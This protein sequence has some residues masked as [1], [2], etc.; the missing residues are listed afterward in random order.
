MKVL[1]SYG[2]SILLLCCMVIGS[3]V[4]WFVGE[5]AKVVQPVADLFLNLLFTVV[6][7]LIFFSLASSIANMENLRK[8]GK[9]L[10]IMAGIFILTQV[11]ASFYMAGICI[12]FDPAKGVVVDMTEKVSDLSGSS[13]FLAMF[14]V[15]DFSL[16]WSRSNLM[17]LIVAAIFTGVAI[18]ACGEKGKP[19]MKFMDSLTHILIKIVSYIMYIAPIG[20]GCFFAVLVGEYGSQ[21]IGPLSRTI[22]IY[23]VAAVIYFFLSS[24]AYAWIAGGLAAFKSFWKHIIPPTLTSLGTCSSAATIPSNLLAAENMNIPDDVKDLTITMGCNLHKDG[25]CLITIL[26]I[27]FMCTMFNMNFLDPKILFTAILIS[28]VASSVMGAIPGGGYVGEIFII[29]AFGFPEVSIPIMVLIGTI[30]DAPATTINATGDTGAAMVIARIMNGKN[31]M[32]KAEK[33]AAIEENV[34]LV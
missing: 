2:F 32:K 23:M 28:V 16:L 6:V 11:I 20:L 34:T 29:S 26:K 24:S 3:I 12:L 9:M 25:A 30:T 5:S 27:A 33:P 19:V 31:W 10:G 4:G 13:N 18:V 15:K 21:L 8:L 1:K 22:I 7:P 14:T 17:A